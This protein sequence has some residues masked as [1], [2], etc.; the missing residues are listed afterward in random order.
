ML[1][2]FHKGIIDDDFLDSMCVQKQK[3]IELNRYKEYDVALINNEVLGYVWKQIIDNN[4]AD[5]E[6]V[7]LYVKY[8]YRKN[9]IGKRI[10]FG[11]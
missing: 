3:Q 5:C 2:R 4:I 8:S 9:G 11:F 1:K 7:A 6:I 10:C